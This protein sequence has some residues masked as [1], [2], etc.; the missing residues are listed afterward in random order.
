MTLGCCFTSAE[1]FPKI[2]INFFVLDFVHA[3]K[4]HC[5]CSN[6]LVIGLELDYWCIL[7]QQHGR[8]KKMFRFVSN[9]P[10]SG[11]VASRIARMTLAVLTIR[12]AISAS[13]LLDGV[14][15]GQKYR[16][17]SI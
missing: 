2:Q 6:K 16:G 10:F 17:D 9:V 7:K 1:F 11:L 5:I 15:A 14:V 8:N 13:I 3:G 12:S 4:A